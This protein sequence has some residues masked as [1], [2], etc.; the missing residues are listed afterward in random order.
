APNDSLWYDAAILGGSA[1][2]PGILAYARFRAI[3]LGDDALDCR[4]VEF[5]D[6]LNQSTT[7]ACIG[8]V[9]HVQPV[10]R[11]LT[12]ATVGSGSVAA[13]PV[14]ATYDDGTTVMLAASLAI[15]SYTLTSSVTGS[16]AV[17]RA[18]DLATYPHFTGVTLTAVPNTGWHFVAWSGDTAAATPALVLTMKRNR[19]LVANF[20]IDTHTL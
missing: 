3:G 11:T 15:I 10:Q 5:R 12:L 16:G 1:S 7:P 8:G 9:I 2:G 20:L 18:P 4:K 14:R 19:T 17:T 13:D 6:A